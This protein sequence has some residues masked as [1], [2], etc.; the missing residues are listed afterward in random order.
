VRAWCYIVVVWWKDKEGR[1]FSVNAPGMFGYF[2]HV[3][4]FADGSNPV[5]K[6][7]GKEYKKESG[8][9]NIISRVVNGTEL[10]LPVHRGVALVFGAPNMSGHPMSLQLVVDH[11]DND[12]TNNHVDNLQWLTQEQNAEKG[13]GPNIDFLAREKL[14]FTVGD[15]GEPL[16]DSWVLNH[17]VARRFKGKWYF[18]FTRDAPG[19]YGESCDIGFPL[20]GTSPVDFSRNEFVSVTTSSDRYPS[21]CRGEMTRALLVHV[22]VAYLGAAENNSGLPM[23]ETLTV[24]HKIE[25]NKADY[26]L[27]NLQFLTLAQ[28]IRKSTEEKMR[29]KK[30]AAVLAGGGGAGGGGG[31]K[32]GQG[33]RTVEEEESESKPAPVLGE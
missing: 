7:D 4:F 24:D 3:I 6:Y 12:S 30:E 14:E 25:G 13:D 26:R 19:V 5:N 15:D 11:V 8:G 2:S 27:V 9:Y 28:N 33:Q 31:G 21:V 32:S 16:G 1:S 10:T 29:K 18:S 23:S 17:M 22:A 20:D